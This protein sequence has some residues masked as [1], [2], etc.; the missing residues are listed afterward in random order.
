VHTFGTALPHDIDG[1][2]GAARSDVAL[3]FKWVV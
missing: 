1:A 3:P 2:A